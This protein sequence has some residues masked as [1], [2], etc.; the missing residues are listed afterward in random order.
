MFDVLLLVHRE[1]WGWIT[2]PP[3]GQGVPGLSGSV[4][5]VPPP[6]TSPP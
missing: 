6:G 2:T 1:I 5:T 4:A 3:D